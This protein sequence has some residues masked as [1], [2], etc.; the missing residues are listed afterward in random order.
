MTCIQVLVRNP[1]VKRP[2][3]LFMC[4][5]KYDIENEFMDIV[6]WGQDSFR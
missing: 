1:D 3:G 2:F 6:V 4:G 5:W